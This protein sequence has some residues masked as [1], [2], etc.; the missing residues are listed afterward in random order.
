MVWTATFRLTT[1]VRSATVSHQRH[2]RR[3]RP[4]PMPRSTGEASPV[5]HAQALSLTALT[6]VCSAAEDPSR[7]VSG[8]PTLDDVQDYPAVVAGRMRHSSS[9]GAPTPRVQQHR[10]LRMAIE[11]KERFMRLRVHA[12]ELS[13]AVIEAA[14]VG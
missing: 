14:L 8:T 5:R 9:E 12:P 1:K 7:S 10:R 3:Q 11:A 4:R 6:P 13:H 2:A